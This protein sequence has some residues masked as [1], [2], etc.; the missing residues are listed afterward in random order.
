MVTYGLLDVNYPAYALPIPEPDEGL[1][2]K[3]LEG[4]CETGVPHQ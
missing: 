2:S 1:V 3:A 4:M